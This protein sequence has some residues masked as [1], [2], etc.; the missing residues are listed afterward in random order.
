MLLFAVHGPAV[1]LFA[2]TDLEPGD[3]RGTDSVPDAR[4]LQHRPPGS[5]G[6]RQP[7]N[8]QHVLPQTRQQDGRTVHQVFTLT[9]PVSQ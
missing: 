3:G 8:G 1:A 9:F 5:A 4:R 7:G 2:A 6:G